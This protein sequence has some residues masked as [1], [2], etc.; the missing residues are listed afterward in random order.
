[1]IGSGF[2]VAPLN[3]EE[4]HQDLLIGG[5]WESFPLGCNSVPEMR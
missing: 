1:M 4:G 5:E 3:T 2:D